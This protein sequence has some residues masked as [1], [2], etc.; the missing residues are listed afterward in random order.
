MTAKQAWAFKEAIIQ[1][2]EARLEVVGLSES[3]QAFKQAEAAVTNFKNAVLE[4]TI[5]TLVASGRIRKPG[6]HG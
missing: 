2:G 3:E 6:G 4:S 5:A 1:A